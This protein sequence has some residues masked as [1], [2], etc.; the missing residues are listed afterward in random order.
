MTLK[1]DNAGF[2]TEW[3]NLIHIMSIILASIVITVYC[4]YPNL[5]NPVTRR[6]IL[7]SSSDIIVSAAE[8]FPDGL[9]SIE[10]MVKQF[11]ITSSI[12]WSLVITMM[13]YRSVISHSEKFAESKYLPEFCVLIPSIALTAFP[14]FFGRYGE[15]KGWC[16]IRS[17]GPG[18]VLGGLLQG[19]C[20]Y[21]PLLVSFIVGM[22]L[23][24]RVIR[25]YKEIENTSSKDLFWLLRFP[26]VLIICY[27]FT[28]IKRANDFIYEEP[29]LY[30]TIVSYCTSKSIGIINSL[31]YLFS[32]IVFKTWKSSCSMQK[33][34]EGHDAPQ[35]V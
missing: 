31:M 18:D 9:C 30:I 33:V 23:S 16:W 3:L 32:E 25:E 15:A 6:I 4:I 5:R 20:F 26:L 22:V 29:N 35:C 8:L 13:I 14:L 10:G 21:L 7:M 27:S 19:L 1:L 34:E 17:E 28:F 11:G 2:D 24:V 12:C